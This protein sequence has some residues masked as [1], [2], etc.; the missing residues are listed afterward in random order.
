MHK[1]SQAA[2]RE[3]ERDFVAMRDSLASHG[4]T[5][6][7]SSQVDCELI[8]RFGEPSSWR[9]SVRREARLRILAGKCADMLGS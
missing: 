7:G 3:R 6:T 4:L 8:R 1:M 9:D 2:Y 5:T